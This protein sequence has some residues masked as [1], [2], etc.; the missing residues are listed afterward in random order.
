ME[1]KINQ[2]KNIKIRNYDIIKRKGK[3]T[4]EKNDK[5]LTKKKEINNEHKT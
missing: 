5:I 3:N 2:I 4:T 1:I